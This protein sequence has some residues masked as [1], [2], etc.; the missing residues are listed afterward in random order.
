MKIIQNFYTLIIAFVG[1]IGGLLWGYNSDW[2]YEP[3]ILLIISLIEVLAYFLFPKKENENMASTNNISN[4][5]IAQTVNVNISSDNEVHTAKN[6]LMNENVENRDQL[7]EL[8]KNKIGILFIDDDKNF[9]V[10]KILRDSGWKNTKTITDVKSLD[11]PQIKN[12]EIIFVDING[13]GKILK[14]ENEGLDLALMLKQ[15]Y[16]TEKRV[17]IYSANKNNNPFHEAWDKTDGKLEKNALPYQFLNMVENY[18]IDY[19]N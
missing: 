5:S 12:S 11:I 16:T 2:D 6:N 8:K 1:V 7:I 9:S 13:V 17:I 15:K 4:N 18:S 14:L 19:Y 3:C 10:V